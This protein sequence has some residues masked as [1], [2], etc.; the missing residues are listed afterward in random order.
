MQSHNSHIIRKQRHD[1]STISKEFHQYHADFASGYLLSLIDDAHNRLYLLYSFTDFTRDRGVISNRIKHEGLA[2]V[3]RTLPQLIDGLLNLLEYGSARFPQFKLQRGR[4]YPQLFRRMFSIVLNECNS[5]STEDQAAAFDFLYSISTAFKKLRGSPDESSHQQHYD[6]F[7]SVDAEIGAIDF[8]APELQDVLRSI[9]TQWNCFAGELNLDDPACIPRPGPGA[10]VG[11][12]PKHA[13]YAPSVLFEQLDSVFPYEEWFYPHGWDVV[14]QSR[15]FLQLKNA[16]VPQP[17]S[18]YLVV[19]KTFLKWRGICKEANEVQFIQQ[20]LRRMLY[21]AIER[22]FSHGIPIRDQSVHR[23]E[24]L[25]ASVERNKATI[26]ESEASDRIARVLIQ[27]MTS[28]TPELQAALLA[29]STR[30]IKPPKWASQTDMLQTHKFAPMGSAVCFPIM[31]IL[32]YF[33]VKAI[34]LIYSKDRSMKT[35]QDLCSQVSV[36][37]DDIVLPSSVVPLVYE[38]L[39]KFGMKINRTKSYVHSHFRESCG[40]HAYKGVNVTPVYIKYT[41]FSSTDAAPIKRLA[42]LFVNESQ[43]SQKGFVNTA[44]F[45]K[46]YIT[47]HWGKFPTVAEGVPVVGFIRPPFSDELTD[48][49]DL[50][51]R[52]VS[53]KWDR[54]YQSFKYRLNC[55]QVETVKGIIP[56][57][58]EGYLR[59]MCLAPKRDSSYSWKVD[60]GVV[61]TPFRLDEWIRRVDDEALPLS[62][63]RVPMY[64]SALAGHTLRRDLKNPASD[65]DNAEGVSGQCN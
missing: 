6:D 15:K 52:Q 32:H 51:R 34:I 7:V 65:R 24:A 43:L 63:G 49:S 10:T 18:E 45:L 8:D 16:A 17:H 35:L 13:R 53:R 44:A 21:A 14:L 50:P 47:K 28:T 61:N 11:K 54:H 29:C 36:Y 9:S 38:W 40:M 2:F 25:D 26:D 46:G 22:Y 42:S 27:R 48:F 64:S 4:N 58:T 23:K 19:P 39:P 57:E 37:G 30:W 3:V 55:Y 20:A 62:M 1:V 56:S 5:Y 41:N 59:Q 60:K 31:S 12:T 33:L